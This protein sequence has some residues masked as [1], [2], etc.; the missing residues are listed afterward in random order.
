MQ[1]VIVDYDPDWPRAY[2]AEYEKIRG[3]LGTRALRIEH[4][5]STAFPN[6]P[7][8]P[9][10]DV[11]LVVANSACEDDYAPALIRAGYQLRICEPD[12]FEHRMFNDPQRCVNLHVFSDG[13]SEVDCMLAFRDWLRTCDADRELY[14]DTKRKLAQCDWQSTQNY[15]DA[16]TTVVQE[17]MTRALPVRV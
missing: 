6:L 15:A 7:A 8:K 3:A 9:V 1:V 12:W 5:G 2:Q 10:I 16:K 14:A 11:V 13:C 4:A 17:I